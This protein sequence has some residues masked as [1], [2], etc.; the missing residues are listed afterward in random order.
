MINKFF[1]P[2]SGINM[3]NFLK[4]SIIDDDPVYR[5]SVRQILES[6][7]VLKFCN[8]YSSGHSFLNSLGSPFQPDVC[9]IDYY[10]QDMTGLD[11]AKA[12]QK[13]KPAI[14][15]VIM[16]GAPNE[17][18]FGEA[19]K[20]GADYVEKGPRV[21]Y[22]IQKLVESKLIDVNERIISLNKDK[23][24][25]F[26]YLDLSAK[27]ESVK[28]RMNNLSDTQIR[29]LKLKRLGISTEDIANHL[30]IDPVT[31]RTHFHRAMK[32]LALPDL[33]DYL[34]DEEKK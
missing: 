23:G 15:L 30:N 27:L 24:I 26:K 5:N 7:S 33:L 12:I 16:T 10:L 28:H 21:E 22:I 31:V 25:Q 20:I 18:S 9:L 11:C 29:V 6:S 13:R 14:H 8:E 1:N 32:K 17:K 3:N 2:K 4:V 19:M 34:L